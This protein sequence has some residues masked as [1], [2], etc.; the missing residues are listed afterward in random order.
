MPKQALDIRK[1]GSVQEKIAALKARKNVKKPSAAETISKL[2]TVAEKI[3]ALKN[4]PS[5][6]K[7]GW[8]SKK[9]QTDKNKISDPTKKNN[10]IEGDK[11]I[12]TKNNKNIWD[13]TTTPW[14]TTKEIIK[15]FDAW[16]QTHSWLPEGFQNLI[17]SLWPSEEQKALQGELMKTLQWFWSAPEWL[18][19]L[20][21]QRTEAL[22]GQRAFAKEAL[23]V[24][25]QLEWLRE[26]LEAKWWAITKTQFSRMEEAR[27]APLRRSLEKLVEWRSL[28]REDIADIDKTINTMVSMARQERTD[29]VTALEK[30]I[31]MF[32][33]TEN[34]KAVLKTALQNRTKQLFE[35]DDIDSEKVK[36]QIIRWDISSL[37]E[38]QQL[39]IV[40]DAVDKV[41]DSAAFKWIETIRTRSQIVRDIFDMVQGWVAVDQAVRTNLTEH[42]RNKPEAIARKKDL[43]T[44]RKRAE[45]LASWGWGWTPKTKLT[46]TDYRIIDWEHYKVTVKDWTITARTRISEDEYKEAIEWK[47]AEEPIITTVTDDWTTRTT[48]KMQW[49][50]LIE[51]TTEPSK[52]SWGVTKSDLINKEIEVNTWE[53]N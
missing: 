34:Q 32:G 26:W 16:V 7:L 52:K 1:L 9:I 31:D 25:D 42:M 51:E 12:S 27:W 19:D 11:M 45:Q 5:S 50:I 46:E 18:Q 47:A 44:K 36:A 38:R 13:W 3:N 28:M 24:S 17:D 10:E 8:A 20:L 29:K 4:R 6:Q 23:S 30:A 48:R 43:E 2:P 53:D 40:Q 41:L 33:W 14:D 35:Q 21:D 22:A 49:D 39:L 37:P 15:P